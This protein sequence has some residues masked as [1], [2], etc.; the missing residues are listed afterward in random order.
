NAVVCIWE[1]K[2]KA[3]NVSLELRPLISFV[4]YHHL[5]HADPRFDAVF[6]E[7]KGR[8]RLRPYEELPELY[9]GHNSLAVEK[10]GYWYRDFELAVEEERGFDFREDLFQPFAMKFDL[11]KPAVAIAATEPVESKKAAKLETAERKRRA[12]LIAK[13]GAETDVEMQLVLT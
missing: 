3:K 2:G 9:I 13:A 8:I 10:T 11:S 12:D 1:L 6:E 4:D 5:Q 7:A